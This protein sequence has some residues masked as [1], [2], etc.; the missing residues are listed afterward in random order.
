MLVLGIVA[1]PR[2][3]HRQPTTKGLV[4]L[5]DERAVLVE[6]Q[7]LLLF[8]LLVEVMPQC[9]AD[10]VCWNGIMQDAPPPDS[11]P[12]LPSVE[13][14][15][16]LSP[17]VGAAVRAFE[18]F[19]SELRQTLESPRM[20][21]FVEQFQSLGQ[22]ILQLDVKRLA[23]ISEALKAAQDTMRKA[24][25]LGELGWTLPTYMTPWRLHGILQLND[26]HLI[27]LAF[28]EFYN[29]S[30][31]KAYQQLRNAVLSNVRLESW[32]PLLRQCCAAYER[33][34][35]LIAVPSLLTVME[36]AIAKPGKIAFVGGKD[37]ASFFA[38]KIATSPCESVEQYMWRSVNAFVKTLFERHEFDGPQPEHLNRHWILHGRDMPD[39]DQSDCLRLL[40]A[41]VAITRLK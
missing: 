4:N 5:L 35:Y 24:E 18:E 2:L 34:E 33:Q 11:A 28:V 22:E 13:P 38:E 7:E 12:N 3:N 15:H 23:A 1:S 14:Y 10:A 17:E 40:Q 26:P 8:L 37:R 29:E 6:L 39:W 36:G 31:G 27:D 21:Q 9:E 16:A 30:D 41:I 19:K 32:R 20:R 25:L